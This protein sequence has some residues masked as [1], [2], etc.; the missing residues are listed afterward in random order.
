MVINFLT[1]FMVVFAIVSFWLG[2]RDA[3]DVFFAL[4]MLGLLLMILFGTFLTPEEWA[5]LREND[6]EN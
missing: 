1:I 6:D 5:K 2:Y 4:G 3:S